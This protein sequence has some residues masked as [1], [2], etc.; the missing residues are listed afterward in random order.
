MS[1]PNAKELAKLAAACR[2]AGIQS[3]K[4]GG[5]EF[6][7]TDAPPLTTRAAKRAS[8]DMDSG[9]PQVEELTDE[10]LL[11]WSVL[12]DEKSTQ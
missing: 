9:N 10:Q 7:L 2:K 1:L 3:F 4:G 11:G 8:E 12:D 6:T 5:I